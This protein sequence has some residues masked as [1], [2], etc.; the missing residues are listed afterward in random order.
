MIFEIDSTQLAK[1]NAWTAEQDKKA[2]ARQKE[3]MSPEDFSL[4]TSD[5]KFPYTGAIGGGL[6][7]SFTMTSLG[8]VTKVHYALT[9]ETLDVSDYENW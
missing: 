9:D 5:G 2:I 7:Y 1:I 8:M 3:S 4:L 6:T